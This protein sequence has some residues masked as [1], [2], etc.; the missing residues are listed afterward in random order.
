MPPKPLRNISNKQQLEANREQLRQAFGIRARVKKALGSDAD[1]LSAAFE[2]ANDV[3]TFALK[4]FSHLMRDPETGEQIA[5]AKFHGEL[6]HMLLSEKFAAIAAPREHAK[7]TIVSCIFVLYCVCHKLRRFIL[8]ISDTQEQAALQLAAVKAELEGNDELRQ[9]FGDLVGDKKWDVNDCRTKGT[10]IS[11]AARGAGQSLRGLRYRAWRPDLVICDDLEN[12]EGVAN[13][14][15]RAKLEHWFK[16][17]VMNLGKSCQIFVVGTIL[18]Y[19]SLLSHLLD[20]DK[21]K[22]YAKRTY[23]AVDQEWTPASVLW[24]EKWDTQSLKDKAEDLGEVLFNQ[25]FR[26]MPISESTQVFKESFILQHAYTRESLEMRERGGEEF[27]TISYADPAIS[28]KTKADDFAFVTLKIDSKGFLYVFRSEAAKIPY[29]KQ[30]D[31][32]VSRYDM[33]LPVVVGVESIAYQDALKQTFEERGRETGRY[34]PIV[35]VK[36][37]TDKFL[38]ISTMGPLVENGTIRFCLDGTQKTLISQLMYLG[39]MRD[40]LADALQGAVAL[41]RAHNF[42]PAISTSSSQL[43][44]RDAVRTSMTGAPNKQLNALDP[45]RHGRNTGLV[46]PDR[47]RSWR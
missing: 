36:N 8:L 40:D 22:R 28:Q 16:A 18:H 3:T 23:Q 1:L 2:V 21:F 6:Y 35:G 5:P 7:S 45:R 47:S 9:D 15:T 27:V 43:G 26:N 32:L 33:D 24:P 37:L 46:Q 42:K 34:I 20:P 13:P 19:D 17:V 10:D 25:E 38:R 12:E 31:Y 11:L 14:E 29:T 30:V 39:K 4:Y 44:N 41:A